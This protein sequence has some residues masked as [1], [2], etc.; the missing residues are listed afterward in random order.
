MKIVGTGLA[1]I[2]ESLGRGAAITLEGLKRLNPDAIEQALFVRL[3]PGTNPTG[4]RD[5]PRLVSRTAAETITPFEF[6]TLPDAVLNLELIGSVPALSLIMGLMAAAVLA[7]VLA[8]AA[9]A[10]RRDIAILQALGFSRSDRTDDRVAVDDLR[11][12]RAPHRDTRRRRARPGRLRTRSREPRGSPAGRHTDRA[13]VT[14]AVATLTLTV[15]LSIVPALRVP[16]T[17]PALL[18]SE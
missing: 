17:R 10:R 12:G 9:R 1:P 6:T 15:V 14:V 5:G 4:A 11:R 7:H 18:H 2:T 16:R 8:V 3:E 13:C